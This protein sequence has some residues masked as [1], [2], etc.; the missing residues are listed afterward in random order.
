M[1]R[2]NRKSLAEDMLRIV[3]CGEYEPRP[4][5]V[6]RI[7]DA[8][9]AAV[10]ETRL[11]TPS[12]LNRL[13]KW[14]PE[15]VEGG[16]R[17]EVCNETTLS[18]A[19]RLVVEEGLGEVL[20]LNFASA[21]NPG[22]GFLGGSQAQEES[23]AR[24]SALYACLTAAPMYYEVNRSCRT[25]MY[26]DHMILSP[27]VPVFRLD[28]GGLLDEPYE[29]SFITAPAVNAGAVARNEPR[30]IEQIVPTMRRRIAMVLALA[31]SEGYK[32]LVL[33]AW[34]C[35]VFRN[36]PEEIAGLFAEQLLAGGV[37]AQCF[38]R[39]VFAVLDHPGGESIEAFEQRFS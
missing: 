39:I 2:L 1:N 32:Q 30:C 29:V 7:A 36:D 12:E 13:T 26:T 10:G 38:E 17:I 5:V 21:K 33:G 37:Y 20:C 35:G 14:A 23:L 16:T 9:E 24:S 6:V 22:G 19:H 34:G 11:F 18:A 25:T 31:A 27:D 4:G 3:E 15:P 28:D 8:V